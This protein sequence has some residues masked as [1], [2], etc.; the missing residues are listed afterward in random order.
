MISLDPYNCKWVGQLLL[1]P[2][3]KE[4]LK[5][6][7]KVRWE[8]TEADLE[9]K[10]SD[11]KSRSPWWPTVIHMNTSFI[12]SGQ[13]SS[14]LDS[15]TRFCGT[16]YKCGIE[17]QKK[18]TFLVQVDSWKKGWALHLE[19]SVCESWWSKGGKQRQAHCEKDSGHQTLLRGYSGRRACQ[20][21]PYLPC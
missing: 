13:H 21:H 18:K 10:S 4:R 12:K 7:S 11:L 16:G 2:V 14:K 5:D 15:N 19:A 9:P 17:I 3:F 8:W 1:F 20:W 6:L